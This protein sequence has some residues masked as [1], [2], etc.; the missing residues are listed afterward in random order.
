MRILHLIASVN[1]AHGGPIE[2]VIQSSLVWTAAGH[3]R[4]IAS[5][6]CPEDPWV[7]TCP[8]KVHA[9][10]WG[11]KNFNFFRRAI[12]W[13][14]YGFTPYMVP[15]IKANYRDYDAIVVNGLW[16]YIALAA[17][18]ALVGTTA[19]YVVYPHGMLDPWFRKAYPVKN[20]A[21]QVFWIFSEG[22]L[23]N[24]A[25]AVI[26][27]T[28]DERELARK[29]FWPYHVNESVIGYGTAEPPPPSE[30]GL[31][32]FLSEFP[33]LR[34]RKY[35]LFL[36]RKHPK[37]GIDLLIKAFARCSADVDL[38]IAG[39]DQ[40]GYQ[41]ELEALA[42]R[43]GVNHRV[44]WSGM[45][46]GDAKWAAFR[47]CEALVLPSHQENFGIVVAE[48]MAC[49]KPV[50][51]SDKVNIWHEVVQY[52]AGLVAPDDV[53]GTQFLLDQFFSLSQFEKKNM[54]ASARRCFEHNFEIKRSA[55]CLLELLANK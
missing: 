35:L 16:N 41:A 7:E 48:A 45:L 34:S 37:K 24:N 25:Y 27:T 38:L 11:G 14:R 53:A 50:L 33:R 40:F 6:D 21:K 36:S 42:R 55:M 20:L 23:L 43:E 9:L 49:G 18:R 17:A 52:Q 39:P 19:K 2:G 3:T 46:Q 10:G 51:I 47:G 1:P 22:K 31:N 5:L 8:V 13:L 15:W 26:F 4:E 30:E 29:S 32:L 54:G 12:P 44:V 28:A